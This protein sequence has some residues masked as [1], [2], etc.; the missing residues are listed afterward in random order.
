M[1]NVCY[2]YIDVSILIIVYL[3]MLENENPTVHSPEEHIE[4]PTDDENME[5]I[6]LIKNPIQNSK[7][8]IK[9]KERVCK[10]KKK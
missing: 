10:G 5:T 3:R 4:P 8:E 6:H 9:K 7:I 2:K 1:F